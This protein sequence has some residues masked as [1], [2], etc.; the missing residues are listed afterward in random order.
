MVRKSGLSNDLKN[1]PKTSQALSRQ[2]FS[3]TRFALLSKKG[4]NL[5]VAGRAALICAPGPTTW[6]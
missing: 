5:E 4:Y 1:G 3:A 2:A 6:L